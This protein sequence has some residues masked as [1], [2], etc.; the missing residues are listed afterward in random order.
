MKQGSLSGPE[1]RVLAGQVEQVLYAMEIALTKEALKRE[2][3]TLTPV[4]KTQA[5]FEKVNSTKYRPK[6][7]ASLSPQ[8]RR[9]YERCSHL[10]R[11][12]AG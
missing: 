1:R 2:A 12:L 7:L 4:L 6:V 8:N 5:C 11:V 9:A 3:P 10:V